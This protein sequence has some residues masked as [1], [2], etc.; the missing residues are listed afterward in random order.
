VTLEPF[1]V[2]GTGKSLAE[3]SLRIGVNQQHPVARFG[4]AATEV[5]A[6]RTFATSSFL[7]DETD[8]FQEHSLWQAVFRA[9]LAGQLPMA[10][11]PKGPRSQEVPCHKHVTVVNDKN[12]QVRV[13]SVQGYRDPSNLGNRASSR[14]S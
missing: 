6:A 1:N 4:K 5:K 8:R 14:S 11:R 7:I 9:S 2:L 12:G 10:I 3:R 13:G